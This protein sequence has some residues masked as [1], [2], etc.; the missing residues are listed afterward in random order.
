MRGTVTMIGVDT[1]MKRLS[2]TKALGRN[3][4]PVFI[5]V[6]DKFQAIP[7]KAIA[8]QKDPVTGRSWPK[9]APITMAARSGGGGNGKRL[10]DTGQLRQS[11]QASFRTS[12]TEMKLGTNK[13]QARILQRGGRITPKRRSHLW[14]PMNYTAKRAGSPH[15][16]WK[17][18][19]SKG[20]APFIFKSKKGN[21]IIAYM[22]GYKK[23]ARA[24]Q[25]GQ[26]K[27][28]GGRA[29]VLTPMFLGKKFVRIAATPYLGF[30]VQFHR[31]LRN[32]AARHLRGATSG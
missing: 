20:W 19:E 25:Y 31:D 32:E 18:A 16:W 24:P 28:R 5:G 7:V 26:K 3:F 29:G 1:L 17:Q 2:Q 21:L 8:Q 23:G 22:K 30:S 27:A 9:N 10:D 4:E 13:P 14:M 15:R 6:A 12:S 11:L